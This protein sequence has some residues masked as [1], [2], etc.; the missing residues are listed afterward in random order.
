MGVFNNLSEGIFGVGK[1]LIHEAPGAAA[2]LGLSAGIP[3]AGSAMDFIQSL[4]LTGKQMDADVRA[5]RAQ[6]DIAD[7]AIAREKRMRQLRREN[8][9]RVAQSMPDVY[10]QVSAGRR[11]PKGSVVIGGKPRTDLLQELADRM[12]GGGFQG[13]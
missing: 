11:L 3:L 13:S 2:G 8:I 7:I 6:E 4:D 9:A 5:K 1:D 12:I 10:N